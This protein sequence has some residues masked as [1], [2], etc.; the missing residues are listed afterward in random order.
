[1]R[2]RRLVPLLLVAAATG[3]QATAPTVEGLADS[4]MAKAQAAEPAVTAEL[5]AI[6]QSA[7]AQLTGLEHRFKKRDSLIRKI[8][9]RLAR[10][11]ELTTDRVR[12][13]DALRY[14]LLIEDDPRGLYLRTVREVVEEFEADG[15]EVVEMKNYWPR[16]DDYS[17]INSVFRAPNGLHWELQFH[18]P[19]SYRTAKGNRNPY[20]RMRL[21]TTPP[22]EQR[23]LYEQMVSTWEGVAIPEGIL[24]P[25]AIHER[26]IIRKREPPKPVRPAR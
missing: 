16:G 23:R 11:P 14:T 25:G 1:M 22:D 9:T 3:C 17:G 8:R 12:I 2:I 19:G 24:V 4:L 6:A 18:T 21:T 5:G 26:A 13:T 20:E 10:D 15:H 7:P